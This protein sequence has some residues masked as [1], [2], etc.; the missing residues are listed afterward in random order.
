VEVRSLAALL[1]P[2]LCSVVFI[3]ALFQVLFL[4]QGTTGLFR[5]SD[6]GWHIRNGEAIL[7][8][9]TPPVVDPFS[10]TRSGAQWLAWEWL[11]DV[12]LGF[13]HSRTGLAG[14]SL[15]AAVIIAVTASAA[16]RLALSLGANLFFTAA[17]SVLLLGTT[18]L[19]W[20]A[21]PHIFSWAFAVVFVSVAEQAR[22]KLGT[23][24]E[25]CTSRFRGASLIYFLPVLACMWANM[26]GSFLLGPGILLIYAVGEWLQ[27]R[28]GVRFVMASLVSLLATFI[29]PYGWR[30]HSHIFDYLKNDYLMNHIA[31][32]RSYN[33]HNAGALYVELFLLVGVIG[34]VLMFRQHAIGPALL[35]LLMLHMSLYSARHLPTAAVLL[36]PLCAVAFT[37]EVEAWPK[38]RSF[39]DYSKRFRVI[40]SKVSGFVPIALSFVIAITGLTILS[41]SGRVGFAREKFPVQ[42]VDYLEK[43][44]HSDRIFAKD[45][46]GGYLI[47]RFAGKTKVF[48]DGRSDFYGRDLLEAQADLMELRPGWS[49]VLSD[50]DVR[51]VLVPPDNALA[52]ALQ[53]SSG[54]KRVYTDSV[55][56]VFEKV[57]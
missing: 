33:F 47:Y 32:Y 17:A 18:S 13:V 53:L 45:Q 50:Y 22:N 2:G 24:P 40:D 52:S 38:W 7:A 16:A 11:S 1:L 20:L 34:A 51:I 57:S 55:A 28:N 10:Y 39:V 27:R 23:H 44:E 26:H 36:L 6:T 5:D 30:L 37:R 14:V 43:N 35:S 25:I 4:S 56:A 31:E 42:A 8:S 29:N 9:K 15:L 41:R 49:R 3:V 48:I 46:W 12:T 21:R 19:H 54:W